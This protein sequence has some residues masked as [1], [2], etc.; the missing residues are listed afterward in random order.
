M[1]VAAG[2]ASQPALLA[3]DLK[4]ELHKHFKTKNWTHFYHLA[5]LPLPCAIKIRRQLIPDRTSHKPLHD[6]SPHFRQ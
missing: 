4:P 6:R 3:L 2:I 1:E 5:R